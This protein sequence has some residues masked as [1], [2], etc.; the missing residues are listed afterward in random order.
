M[1]DPE[2][3]LER[4]REEV[5]DPEAGVLLLDVVLGFA[6]HADP[7]GRWPRRSR[8]PSRTGSPDG[9]GRVRSAPRPTPG[10]QPPGGRPRRGG[11]PAGADQRRRR[12]LAAALAG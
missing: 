9:R 6:S 10:A 2:A 4:L 12:P 1:I 5:A 3:R 7:A 8:R 11:R